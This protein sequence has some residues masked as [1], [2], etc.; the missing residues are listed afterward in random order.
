[1]HQIIVRQVDHINQYVSKKMYDTSEKCEYFSHCKDEIT[2]LFDIMQRFYLNY[3]G[4]LHFSRGGGLFWNGAFKL[5][6]IFE[7]SNKVVL[8]CRG[9]NNCSVIITDGL[10]RVVKQNNIN[11]HVIHWIAHQ[12]DLSGKSVPEAIIM[13]RL[14]I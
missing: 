12:G 11:C 3:S 2:D 4:Q 8:D 9:F 10:A 7:N 14:L 6:D 13:E 1:M 5:T